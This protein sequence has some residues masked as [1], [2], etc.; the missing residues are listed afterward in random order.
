MVMHSVWYTVLRAY[1]EAAAAQQAQGIMRT[2]IMH[3]EIKEVGL[4]ITYGL[5]CVA[6]LGLQTVVAW[7]G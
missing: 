6:W 5:P 3:S 2:W 4:F 7:S 1:N